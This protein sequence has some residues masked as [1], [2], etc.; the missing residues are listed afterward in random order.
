MNKPKP[1]SAGNF[2][3][4]G[5]LPSSIRGEGA[6]PENQAAHEAPGI[7]GA[8]IRSALDEDVPVGSLDPYDMTVMSEE[9]RQQC[10]QL[11]FRRLITA[12]EYPHSLLANKSFLPPKRRIII[13]ADNVLVVDDHRVELE[14]GKE[15]FAV[16]QLLLVDDAITAQDLYENGMGSKQE[17]A[18]LL[19]N[20]KDKIGEAITRARRAGGFAYYFYRSGFT[21]MRKVVRGHIA[22]SSRYIG[23]IR[24]VVHIPGLEGHM[25]D[26]S[27]EALP[28]GAPD[29]APNV[30]RPPESA[31]ETPPLPANDM[32]EPPS[33]GAPGPAKLIEAQV[34][35]PLVEWGGVEVIME[36]TQLPEN[37]VRGFIA[38]NRYKLGN[39]FPSARTNQGKVEYS[40]QFVQWAIDSLEQAKARYYASKPPD[41]Q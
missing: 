26:E 7:P 24:P 29:S 5:G 15:L 22:D 10:R 41:Q 35:A 40:P 25:N 20:L 23:F 9:G 38:R 16:N 21:D 6:A 4:A 2:D 3:P 19:A 37:I 39:Q 27:G 36:R 18:R 1:E 28:I 32:A 11:L 17:I 33:R 31:P 30:E 8:A 34:A 14:G 12:A 13:P